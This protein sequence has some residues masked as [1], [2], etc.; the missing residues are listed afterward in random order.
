MRTLTAILLALA[1]PAGGLGAQGTVR[2][3]RPSFDLTW[4]SGAP[5]ARGDG[6]SMSGSGLDARVRA[7]LEGSVGPV[8]FRIEPELVANQNG[9]HPTF[10]SGDPGRSRFASPFYHGDYSADLPS[11]PGDGSRVSLAFGESA[12]WWAG[13][14]TFAGAMTTTPRWGPR[15]AGEGL[16]LGRSAAG[17]PR[18]ELGYAWRSAVTTTRVRWFGG[19]VQEGAWFDADPS[20]DTRPIAGLRVEHER[21][22]RVAIGFSR[23]V[24]SAA[25]RSLADGVLR[26]FSRAR[27]GSAIEF[28]AADVLYADARAG[29]RFWVELAR[30]EAVAGAGAF[31][32][33]PTE[34]LAYRTGLTRR[35]AHSGTAE[36]SATVDLVHLDQSATRT[37][38]EPRDLYTSDVV[39]HGWT[40]QGQPLGSGLGPGGQRQLASLERAGRT[41]RLGAFA[42]RVRWNENAMLREAA[43]ASDRHDVT[44][45]FGVR[46]ARRVAGYD[47]TATFSA[48]RRLN[49]LFQGASSS[50]G[51]EAVDIGVFRLGLSVAP[52]NGAPRIVG[53]FPEP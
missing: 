20:N 50:L 38:T 52:A 32:R 45:Q 46:S 15:D 3:V 34:G 24:M 36:W 47:V 27:R 44:L 28:L 29:I 25:D 33:A 37:D 6:P 22:D 30:Q 10:V 42:E 43:P 1:W 11:R 4:T 21:G 41:W 5:D 39:A 49:Y 7:G 53:V 40:H 35:I 2:V 12:L 16:V 23:T 13:R 26:P 14:R 31:L 8:R 48:G 9:D 51:N 19:A 18:L 17:L